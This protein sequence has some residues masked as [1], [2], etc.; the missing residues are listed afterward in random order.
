MRTAV[1]RPVRIDGSWA[2]LAM[3]LHRSGALWRVRHEMARFG[4][5]GAPKRWIWC[6]M[7]GIC[8]M[9]SV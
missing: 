5:D 9:A 1:P 2:A 7:T 4:D 6:T 3:N 8:A